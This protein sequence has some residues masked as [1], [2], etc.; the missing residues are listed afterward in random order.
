M[1]KLLGSLTM[2]LACLASTKAYSEEDCSWD[3]CK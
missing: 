3:G 1:K 2:L